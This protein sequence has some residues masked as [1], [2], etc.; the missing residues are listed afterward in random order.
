MLPQW[1]ADNAHITADGKQTL[2]FPAAG[3]WTADGALPLGFY[4]LPMFQLVGL[5]WYQATQILLANDLVPAQPLSIAVTNNAAGYV[6]SQFPA[7]G[8]VVPPLELVTLTVIRQG[9]LVSYTY[10][11]TV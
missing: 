3:M 2:A 9:H 1:S 11:G 7:A 8:V 10:D 5:S 6:W 4:P